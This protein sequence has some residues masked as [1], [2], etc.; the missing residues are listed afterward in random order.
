MG[1]M[2]CRRK[3][4]G[5]RTENSRGGVL[6]D[7]CLREKIIISNPMSF[8]NFPP[9]GEPSILDIFLLKCKINHSSPVSLP[10]LNSNH[11]PV[12]VIFNYNYNTVL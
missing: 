5:C 3:E 8:T 7:F 10:M 12:E 2:N 11:N 1:D 4:W 9:I 6:L